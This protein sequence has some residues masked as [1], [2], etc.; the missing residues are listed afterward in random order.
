MPTSSATKSVAVAF[1]RKDVVGLV[2]CPRRE[3]MGARERLSIGG[4]I[5]RQ[6]GGVFWRHCRRRG[7]GPAWSEAES[8]LFDAAEAGTTGF[9]KSNKQKLAEYLETSRVNTTKA[10]ESQRTAKQQ[11]RWEAQDERD[12]KIKEWLEGKTADEVNQLV[13]SE[14]FDKLSDLAQNRV[15]VALEELGYEAAAEVEINVGALEEAEAEQQF[16][17][18]ASTEPLPWE[19]RAEQVDDEVE[20]DYSDDEDDSTEFA[21]G[22]F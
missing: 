12:R 1:W 3:L 20:E 8:N 17:M 16:Q 21:G 7:P 18:P 9:Y 2:P 15:F 19:N 5:A 6:G 22:R 11:A 4:G 10:R 13:A 14:Q